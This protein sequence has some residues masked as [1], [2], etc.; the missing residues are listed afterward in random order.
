MIIKFLKPELLI[1]EAR[2]IFDLF[3]NRQFFNGPTWFLLALFWCNIILYCITMHVKKLILQYI[4]VFILGFIGWYSG[5]KGWFVPLLMDVAL[6]A[7]PFFAMGYFLKRTTYY[8]LIYTTNIIF[9]FSY[10][11]GASVY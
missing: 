1:T 9:C 7:M 11:Y 5:N 2:G 6:T 4:I 3:D 8:I 10:H